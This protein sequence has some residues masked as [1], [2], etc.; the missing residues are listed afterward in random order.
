MFKNIGEKIKVLAVVIT[1]IGCLASIVGAI[2]CWSEDSIL[3]GFAVLI[4]GCLFSWLGSFLLY[5]MGELIT[6]TTNIARGIQN[7]QVLSAYQ[8]SETKGNITKE[9]IEEI[10]TEVAIHYEIKKQELID[11]EAFDDPEKSSVNVGDTS[12]PNS[13]ECP[14]CFSKI[15]E[16]DAECPNCGYKLK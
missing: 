16:D 2:I 6:Q 5:G 7:M 12:I 10:Q 13:D 8:N 14:N 9:M 15:S 11:E 1:I 4:G 3:I